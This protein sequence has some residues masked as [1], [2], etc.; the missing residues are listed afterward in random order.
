MTLDVLAAATSQADVR[1]AVFDRRRLVADGFAALLAQSDRVQIVGVG[2]SAHA[3]ARVLESTP[4]DVV[5]VGIASPDLRSTAR[6]LDRIPDERRNDGPRLV[7]IVSGDQDIAD[8]IGGP[9]VTVITTRTDPD[10]LHDVVV[11]ETPGEV[12]TIP[13]LVVWPP[14]PPE[15]PVGTPHSELTPRER[16]VLR[17]IENG[18]ST[19]E[20]AVELGI[21]PNTVRTHA[22]RLM[23]KLSVHSRVQAAAI[24]AVEDRSPLAG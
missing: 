17:G 2:T 20:I 23:S 18:L 22:Q 3:V 8:V 10:T 5:V 21:A 24:A 13:P 19:S 1:V 14:T 7:G 9:Q 15:R 16:E 6:L 12:A 4:V 11:S